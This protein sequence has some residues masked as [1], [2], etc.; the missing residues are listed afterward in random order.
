MY[1]RKRKLFRNYIDRLPPNYPRSPKRGAFVLNIEEMA[2]LFH[3]PSWVISPVPGVS[4]IEAKKK[5]PPELPT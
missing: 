3:F 5:P 1:L 2:S 4:R